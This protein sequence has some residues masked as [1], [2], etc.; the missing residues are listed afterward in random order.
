MAYLEK[1]T[2]EEKIKKKKKKKKPVKNTMC[3][4]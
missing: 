1:Q 3:E 4:A 2:R